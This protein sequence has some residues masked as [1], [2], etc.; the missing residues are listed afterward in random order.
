MDQ[1]QTQVASGLVVAPFPD[2]YRPGKSHFNFWCL[3]QSFW[4]LHT[5][6]CHIGRLMG[7]INKTNHGDPQT[8]YF[9]NFSKVL[10]RAGGLNG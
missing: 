3:T 2:L 9:F 6:L 1:G 5:A 4:N 10:L 7:Y 8:I